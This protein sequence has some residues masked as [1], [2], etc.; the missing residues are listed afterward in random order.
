MRGAAEKYLLRGSV[1]R[2]AETLRAF[3]EAGARHVVFKA[4][5]P[6]E[7]EEAHMTRLAEELLPEARRH[8]G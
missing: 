2:C 3:R 1:D 6:T 4:A 8:V 7:A 5:A